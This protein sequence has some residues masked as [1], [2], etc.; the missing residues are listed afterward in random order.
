MTLTPAPTGN[1]PI[2]AERQRPSERLGMCLR[3]NSPATN[4]VG[5]GGCPGSTRQARTEASRQAH[6]WAAKVDDLLKIRPNRSLGKK[7]K[8]DRY[9][10]TALFGKVL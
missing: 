1:H 3:I 7:M 2:T 4:R 8:H 5:N 6:Q 10:A 9:E